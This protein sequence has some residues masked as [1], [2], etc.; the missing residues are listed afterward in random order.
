MLHSDKKENFAED[1]FFLTNFTKFPPKQEKKNVS[2][3]HKK[4]IAE[5]KQKYITQI[6]NKIK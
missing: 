1:R 6:I 2:K 3:Q 4:A 5:E